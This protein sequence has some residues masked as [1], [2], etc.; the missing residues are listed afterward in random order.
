[1][2]R[3]SSAQ[4]LR[5]MMFRNSIS[6]SRRSKRLSRSSTSFC[7]RASS[8]GSL[9]DGWLAISWSWWLRRGQV[10]RSCPARS[11][12]RWRSSLVMSASSRSS[13]RFRRLRHRTI[14]RVQNLAGDFT[15]GRFAKDVLFAGEASDPRLVVLDEWNL[16]QID[17]YLAP[18]LSSIE[19]LLPLRIPGRVNLST[20]SEDDR[21]QSYA[22][23]RASRTVNGCCRKIRCFLRRATVG[24]TSRRLA[25]QSA[26]R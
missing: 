15:A 25:S 19:S 12:R 7:R 18:I 16:A 23:S 24:P 10:R 13:S 2:S 3:N 5:L 4:R 22:R 6:P 11:R 17:T 21:E 9:E 26:G 20:M 1:M 14:P 8:T